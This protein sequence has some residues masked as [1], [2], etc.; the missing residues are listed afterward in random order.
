MVYDN[1]QPNC[2]LMLAVRCDIYIYFIRWPLGETSSKRS[3]KGFALKVR[4]CEGQ[5]SSFKSVISHSPAR[6]HFKRRASNNGGL[7]LRKIYRRKARKAVTRQRACA[8]S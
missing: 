2:N 3:S 8:G 1:I 6:D 7:G 5:P 4:A